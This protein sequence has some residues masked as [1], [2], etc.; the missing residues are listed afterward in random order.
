MALMED[1]V[2]HHVMETEPASERAQAADELI[3]VV[4]SYLK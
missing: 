1:H 2:R 4:R 3:D